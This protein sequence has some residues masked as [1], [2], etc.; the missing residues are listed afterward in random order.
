MLPFATVF[1]MLAPQKEAIL[2]EAVAQARSISGGGMPLFETVKSSTYAQAVA[3]AANTLRPGCDKLLSDAVTMFQLTVGPR[4]DDEAAAI[5][6][7]DQFDEHLLDA[8]GA[9]VTRAV[10]QDFIGEYMTDSNVDEPDMRVRVAQIMADR[11]VDAAVKGRTPGQVLSEIGI[12][13]DDMAKFAQPVQ[14]GQAKWNA[15]AAIAMIDEPQARARVEQIAGKWAIKAGIAAFDPAALADALKLCF[16]EELFLAL[17]PIEALGGTKEDFPFFAAY[18]KAA[19]STAINDTVAAAMNAAI[20][21]AVVETP[22]GKPVKKVRIDK[23][24][25]TDA[26]V[27]PPKQTPPAPSAAMPP[28][29]AGGAAPKD[30]Y[31]NLIKLMREHS[32]DNDTEIGTLIGKTR[33]TVGNIAAGKAPCKLTPDQISNLRVLLGK[34]IAGLQAAL[35]MLA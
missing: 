29:T 18:W 12:V 13:A 5:S 35:A 14:D 33:G 19:S 34:R 26:V 6:W 3:M 2:A 30:D 15:E 32:A 31:A 24:N 25:A 20:V 17:G 7:R 21:G 27:Q 28:A 10:S 22:K 1:T 4:P 8:M 23:E 11:L 16:D 9:D